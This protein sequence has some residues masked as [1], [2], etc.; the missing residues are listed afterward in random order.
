LPP[1]FPSW[2]PHS[3]QKHGESEAKEKTATTP[4]TK[5]TPSFSYDVSYIPPELWAIIAGFASRQSLARLCAASHEF[6]SKFLPLLYG[7]ILDP[8]LTVDQST[9]PDGPTWLHGCSG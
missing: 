8:S 9:A 1:R 2:R 3:A 5:S 4:D 6:Y 7:N